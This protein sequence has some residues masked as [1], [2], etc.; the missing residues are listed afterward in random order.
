MTGEGI[1]LLD[2]PV[3]KSS[4][5][6]VHLLRKLTGIRKIGHAG[7]LDPFA[8]GLMV[9]LVGKSA[10][11]TQDTYLNHDKAYSV[12]LELGTA[13][14]TFDTEGEV[15]ESSSYRPTPQELEIALEQFQGTILQT[16]PMFSAKKVNGKKLYELARKGETVE[17]T[18]REITVKTTLINYDYPDIKLHVECSK[19]TYIRTIAHDL[20]HTLGSCAHAKT[21]RRTRCGPFH[22]DDALTVEALQSPNLSL[23]EHLLPCTES[24]V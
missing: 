17:R 20:G 1:L 21:L 4:F 23:K 9:M 2:K 14:T 19:G 18:P 13:T 15:T 16:P 24:I 11:R 22:L 12:T 5:Y 6:L 10:T 3:G 7:T 8:T